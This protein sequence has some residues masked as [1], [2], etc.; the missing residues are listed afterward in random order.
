MTNN[1]ILSWNNIQK[2]ISSDILC[3]LSYSKLKYLQVKQF[4][5]PTQT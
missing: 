5:K 1:A 3:D 4:L 2:V